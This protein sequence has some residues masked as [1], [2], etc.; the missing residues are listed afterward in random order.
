MATPRSF[1]AT[2][3]D[4]QLHELRS[5]KLLK[6]IRILKSNGYF[7]KKDYQ[8]LADQIKAIDAELA[9]RLDRMPLR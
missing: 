8:T 7:G 2:Q 3:T 6:Q 4:A 1:Y 5:E 9:Y